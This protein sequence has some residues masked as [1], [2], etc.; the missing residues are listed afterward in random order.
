MMHLI[1]SIIISFLFGI[2]SNYEIKSIPAYVERIEPTK[3]VALTFDDGP[4]PY[5]DRLLDFLYEYDVFATFYVMGFSVYRRSE[6]FIRT[7]NLGHEIGNHTWLHENLVYITTEEGIE[8]YTKTSDLIYELASIR[9]K[10]ARPPFGSLDERVEE[11][12]EYLDYPIV[13]WSLDTRDWETRD[14]YKIYNEIMENIFD[15]AIILMHDIHKSTY[16]AIRKVIP[17]LI[18][19]G[20]G[21]KTVSELVGYMESGNIYRRGN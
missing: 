1:L 11:M 2:S 5:T 9:P 17:R 15:G 8:T 10:T 19:M 21:F 13:L 20:F 18:E 14:P 3:F 6:T 4:G 12:H 7:V 16:Y